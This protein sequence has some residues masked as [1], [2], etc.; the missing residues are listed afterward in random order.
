MVRVGVGGNVAN[1]NGIIG[2]LFELAAG[3]NAGGIAVKQQGQQHLRMASFRA[4]SGV[5]HLQLVQVQLGDDIDD[6]A[7]QMLFWKPVLHRRR[8]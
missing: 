5:S 2:G 8:Q 3:K 6:K 7:R 4:D 1:G